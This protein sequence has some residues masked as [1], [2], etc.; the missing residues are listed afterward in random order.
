MSRVKVKVVQLRRQGTGSLGIRLQALPN[1][2]LPAFSAGAHIDLILPGGLTRQYSIASAPSCRAYYEL[3]VK[4][5]PGSRGGS[6]FIHETLAVNDELEI[7]LPR[8]L[9]ALQAADHHVL[10]AGGIGITP[11]LSMA[12]ELM[13]KGQ[14]FT[15]HYYTKSLAEA[16]YVEHLTSGFA[17]GN[18]CL[19]H[20]DQ[21]RSPRQHLPDDFQRPQ[22]GTHL[23]LCGPH[24]LMAHMTEQA[25]RRGWDQ[26][27][28][29]QEAFSA[30][31]G[32]ADAS[33]DQA[34]DVQLQSSGQ[35]VQVNADQSIANALLQAGIEVPV[36]CEQG[37][38]GACLTQVLDG[39][40]CHRDSVMSDAEKGLN[41]QMTL[42]CSRS[43][44]ARLVLGL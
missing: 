26:R 35:L 16:A 3:C 38:C 10:V 34:F 18:V 36:S 5:A 17:E 11:L 9:F 25:I 7:S 37:F 27:Q 23:Y 1:E 29:H 40:P 43:Q 24:A 12:A 8:N 22:P 41:N 31:E 4:Q 15:L 42:C 2:M 14:S 44:S 33:K 13:E 30:P 32:V 21:G 39:I 28:I 19:H 6:R 20:S